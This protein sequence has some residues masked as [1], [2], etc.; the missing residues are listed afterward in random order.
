MEIIKLL[1]HVLN[2]F[3]VFNTDE[4]ADARKF[5]MVL[6]IAPHFPIKITV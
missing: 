2:A 3:N 5:I 6:H 1:L 4:W